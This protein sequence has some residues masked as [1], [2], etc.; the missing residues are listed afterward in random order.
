[1]KLFSLLCDASGSQKSKM[2]GSQTEIL[3]SQLVHNVATK[4]QRLYPCFQGLEIQWNYFWYCVMQAEVRNP[5]W[6]LTNTGNIH[7]SACI[8]RSCKI[9]TAKP[10]AH[11]P[12][13]QCSYALYCVMQ[14]EIIN[15]RWRLT[16]RKY[17]YISLYTSLLH[18]Y[19]DYSHV[20]QVHDVNEAIIY[21]VWYNLKL[22]IQDGGQQ[23]GNTYI[24]ACIQLSCIIPTAIF[25]FSR[26]R[27]SVKL[28]SIFYNAS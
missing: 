28:F 27:I 5:R 7:I 2:A 24:S 14:A 13:V 22:E 20:F 26:S 8:L 9:L 19:N 17:L 23:T 4:F 25:M 18:N 10:Y 3:I 15:P 11:G 21:I 1:M 12:G 16:N 6:R